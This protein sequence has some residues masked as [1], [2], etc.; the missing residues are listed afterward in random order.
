[1]GVALLSGLPTVPGYCASPL[2]GKAVG[3]GWL[4]GCSHRGDMEVTQFRSPG[5]HV[6]QCQRVGSY[7]CFCLAWS[8]LQTW[9]GVPVELEQDLQTMRPS[10]KGG[11]HPE[12][13]R[14]GLCVS[15]SKIS[16]GDPTTFKGYFRLWSH[17]CRRK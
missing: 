9:V 3:R 10:G 11:D 15:T 14:M 1:M 16:P 6:K 7:A 12:P 2:E 5:E 8:E 13:R 4:R 17:V